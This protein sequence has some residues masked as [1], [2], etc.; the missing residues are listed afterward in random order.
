MIKLSTHAVLTAKPHTSLQYSI[1]WLSS[2]VCI[3]KTTNMSR[4]LYDSTY[5]CS[6]N[7]IPYL[8]APDHTGSLHA[9]IHSHLHLYWWS[10][11]PQLSPGQKTVH[12]YP[13]ISTT[14]SLRPYLIVTQ[15]HIKVFWL[16]LVL[17]MA[18][19]NANSK[20]SA[21]GT[22]YTITAVGMSPSESTPCKLQCMMQQHS[23]YLHNHWYNLFVRMWYEW[24]YCWI[25]FR[26]ILATFQ[27]PVLHSALNFW[28]WSYWAWHSITTLVD[29]MFLSCRPSS[30][31]A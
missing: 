19:I 8:Q 21:A 30:A 13:M 20:G 17:I 9:C 10:C 28:L 3:A 15:G 2:T 7:W 1:W 16:W 14:Y 26:H 4:S 6:R 25:F 18:N 22:G 27:T 5:R 31:I 24:I 29:W 11:M 12:Q 23:I